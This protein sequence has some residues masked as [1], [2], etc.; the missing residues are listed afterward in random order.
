[1]LE[2]VLVIT[3]LG[4]RLLGALGVRRFASW[5]ASAAHGMAVMLVITASAHFVPASVTAMPNH[6]DLVRMVPPVVPFADAMVYLTGVL[7]L[8]GAVGLVVAA[9]RWAAG[10]SLAALYVLLLPANIYAAVAHVSFNGGEPTSLWLRVPEQVLYIAIA[11]WVARSA[12]ST[13]VRRVLHLPHPGA[14]GA[15]PVSR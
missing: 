3:T 5:P 7:E 11:V 10:I 1:M 15:T 2:L 14:A 12:D 9:T 13:V 6:A 4:F 8:L